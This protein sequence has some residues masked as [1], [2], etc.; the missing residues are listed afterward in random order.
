MWTARVAVGDN[1]LR[2]SE[3]SLDSSNRLAAAGAPPRG[4][5][6][7]DVMLLERV[8]LLAFVVLQAVAQYGCK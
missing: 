8:A 2:R 5:D 4:E 7:D 1:G 3:H 6:R